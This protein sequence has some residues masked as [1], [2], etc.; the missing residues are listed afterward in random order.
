MYMGCS[1]GF[2]SWKCS[3]HHFFPLSRKDLV[4]SLAPV[5]SFQLQ[6]STK[7]WGTLPGCW[8][9]GHRGQT[10]SS[11]PVDP[12]HIYIHIA[13][14]ENPFN[15]S[16][17]L[18][19]HTLSLKSFLETSV[20]SCQWG[21]WWWLPHPLALSGS[22][23]MWPGRAGRVCPRT[24]RPPRSPLTTLWYLAGIQRWRTGTGPC[25][26]SAPGEAHLWWKAKIAIRS[27]SLARGSKVQSENFNY[28]EQPE[29]LFPF[30]LMTN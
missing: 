9:L 17:P 25:L 5:K 26:F 13:S 21:C 27:V 22:P 28:Q 8:R 15:F 24:Q 4:S 2:C 23:G 10:D 14:I 18:F 16:L 11:K 29:H 12:Q 20:S 7:A 1:S 6:F 3:I 30:L 19:C